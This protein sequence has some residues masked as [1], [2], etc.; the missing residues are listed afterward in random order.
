MSQM[1]LPR[2]ARTRL[3]MWYTGMLAGSLVLLG[4]LGLWTVERSMY[5]HLDELLL[6]KVGVMQTELETDNGRLKADLDPAKNP[7]AGALTAGLDVV[8][9]WDQRQ[10]VVHR[11]AIDRDLPEP[12][13]EVFDSLLSGRADS[14][15]TTVTG[16]TGE[17]IRLYTAPARR[18]GQ[19]MGVIQVGRS[20][21]ELDAVLHQLRL[22][23]GVGAL[24]AIALGGLGGW[25]LAGRALA[26]VDRI[27]RAAEQIGAEDLSRRLNLALPDDELGRLARAFD[28]MIQRLEQV[29]RR[30][31]QFTAD[32]SHELRTPLAVIRSQV[33]VALGRPRE[34]EYYSR[35]LGSVREETLRLERLTENLLV[36]ARADAAMIPALALVELD[37]LVAEVAAGVALRARASGVK[38]LLEVDS[39]SSVLGSEQLI[40]QLLSN[41]LDNALRHTPRGG[42]VVLSLG[43]RN[44]RVMIAVRD[45]GEGI[46]PEH[47]PH[48]TERF[49]RVDQARGSASGG[50]GLGLAICAWIARLH[51]GEIEFQSEPG[52]GTVVTVWFPAGEIEHD[53]AVPES[54]Q[55]SP[56]RSA[57]AGAV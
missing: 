19:V 30:Q 42:E 12:D 17:S 2:R 50:A 28:G 21:A 26:P 20:Q 25:F 43:S 36:L 22:M 53:S 39:A 10:R 23:G 49:Y 37:A 57:A 44:A 11:F 32:A 35:T 6:F 27:T 33:D 51:G 46:A 56:L 52:V 8:R 24:L 7:D 54:V 15:W 34:A 16:S 41:V 1:W 31:Q 29:F 3:A 13:A 48:L 18:K 55:S 4:M 38:L 9:I 45:T 5:G 14:V 47:L 40:T